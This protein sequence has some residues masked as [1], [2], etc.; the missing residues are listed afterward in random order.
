MKRFKM[1]SYAAGIKDGGQ[2]WIT[3]VTGWHLDG[4]EKALKRREPQEQVSM[5]KHNWA[6]NAAATQS[7]TNSATLRTNNYRCSE[8]RR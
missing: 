6:G 3:Q 2:T 4:A 5:A 7:Q 1:V 8:H